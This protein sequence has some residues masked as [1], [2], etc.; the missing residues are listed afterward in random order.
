MKFLSGW[1]SMEIVSHR[2]MYDQHTDTVPDQSLSI[3]EIIQRASYGQP[4][5]GRNDGYYDEDEPAEPIGGYDLTD[6]DESDN[7]FN[8][9]NNERNRQTKS[10]D[11]T[12]TLQDGDNK[13][14]SIAE[15]EKVE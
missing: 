13:G 8:K 7:F 10:S 4:L 1:D 2:R 12:P 5:M 3:R 9:L 11:Q 15:N 14:Q 6:I